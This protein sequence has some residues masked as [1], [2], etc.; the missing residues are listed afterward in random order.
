M[1][2]KTVPRF[3]AFN[4]SSIRNAFSF[5]LS[6]SHVGR[7]GHSDVLAKP[8]SLIGWLVTSHAHSP[9]RSKP[10]SPLTTFVVVINL[11]FMAPPTDSPSLA[12]TPQTWAGGICAVSRS[13]RNPLLTSYRNPATRTPC[14]QC[15]ASLRSRCVRRVA[16]VAPATRM[17][18]STSPCEEG[19]SQ[20]PSVVLAR[21][22]QDAKSHCPLKV[23][24]Y[25]ARLPSRGNTRAPLVG[26]QPAQGASGC[27]L[28]TGPSADIRA[29]RGADADRS[30]HSHR[31]YRTRADSLW[32]PRP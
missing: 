23:Q 14:R 3:C 7:A 26:R 17:E 6:S 10:H 13:Y 21:E 20:R 25:A 31:L 19:D 28:P 4:T 30:R 29:M 2:F 27:P 18:S 24:R 15:I 32:T 5:D 11:F 12:A 16:T 22:A 9:T 1:V 8:T